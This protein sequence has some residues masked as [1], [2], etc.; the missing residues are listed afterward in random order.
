[1]HRIDQILAYFATHWLV[2]VVALV[3]VMVVPA[4]LQQGFQEWKIRR[5]A[6]QRAAE[7]RRQGII[8]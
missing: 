8:H 7:L 5:M 4:K 2:A 6:R 1:M 3:W